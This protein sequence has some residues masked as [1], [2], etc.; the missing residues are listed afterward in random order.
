MRK[1]ITKPS[2][3]KLLPPVLDTINEKENASSIFGP[4]KVG[5][6]TT[7]DLQ[8]ER[9]KRLQQLSELL[10]Y[11][12]K[13]VAILSFKLREVCATYNIDISLLAGLGNSTSEEVGTDDL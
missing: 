1:D 8:I 7:Q 3:L 5:L 12:E 2:H 11:L 9:V 13:E 6:I 10:N 4:V